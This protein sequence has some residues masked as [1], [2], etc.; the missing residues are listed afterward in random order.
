LKF[1]VFDHHPC[2]ETEWLL[3]VRRG[4]RDQHS[5]KSVLEGIGGCAALLWFI[6]FAWMLVQA[7]WE[8]VWYGEAVSAMESAARMQT[9]FSTLRTAIP[10][11][12]QIVAI[13]L[14]LGAILYLL[15]AVFLW[16][17]KQWEPVPPTEQ[18]REWWPSNVEEW[19]N[20]LDAATGHTHDG[21]AICQR[22]GVPIRLGE[23]TLLTD[24]E[25]RALAESRGINS[26]PG[27]FRHTN[28][29]DCA[30]NSGR[31]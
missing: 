10:A 12:L 11:L 22:C 8:K 4:S 24:D 13:Y 17:R 3:W 16:A 25:K 18:Q 31:F 7:A 28:E 26:L 27:A 29:A 19:E 15:I 30:Q 2:A 14:F 21:R 1:G 23:G 9:E 5:M 6:S 20:L